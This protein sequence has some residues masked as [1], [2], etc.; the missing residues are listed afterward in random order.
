MKVAI[1]GNRSL[2]GVVMR[3]QHVAQRLGILCYSLAEID[4]IPHHDVLILVKYHNDFG[5]QIREKCDRLIYDPLDCWSSLAKWRNR[6]PVDFWRWTRA[7]LGFDEIIATSP[8][9]AETMTESLPTVPVHI[10]PHH[11]DPRVGPNWYHPDGPVV[12]AGG[13]RFLGSHAQA[14]EWACNK[15]GRQ[16]VA[17]VG[18][19]CER[20]L[21][22]AS[23]CL[24][25][26]MSPENTDLNVMCKPQVKSENAAAAGLP[27][28]ATYDPCCYSLRPEAAYFNEGLS[29]KDNI[30]RALGSAPLSDPVTLDE[31]AAGIERILKGETCP[32]TTFTG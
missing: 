14:I 20:S 10:L 29:W 26:R 31:H 21:K 19:A 3:G 9:C 17:D 12:Y 5:A 13:I 27:M 2:G 6:D 4:R 8:A 1:I 23:L 28:L 16:F 25:L 18:R 22:G 11:A 7:Q 32:S 30:E 24:N 15:L